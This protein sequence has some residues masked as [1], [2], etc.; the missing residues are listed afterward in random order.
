MQDF[1]EY[2]YETFGFDPKFIRQTASGKRYFA[3]ELL[4]GNIGVCATLGEKYD[5]T[6]PDEIYLELDRH[7][8][9][10]TAY[11]N[12]LL[13]Y[14]SARVKENKDITDLNMN[15]YRHIVFVG[16]F[17][18]V[19]EKLRQQGIRFDYID[20]RATDSPDNRI[21]N[22]EEVLSRADLLIITATAITNGTLNHLL[23]L[24]PFSDKYILGPSS[25]LLPDMAK[26]GIKGIFGTQF[27]P[28]D[29]RVLG[30]ISQDYG[31]RYFLHKG[32]KVMV[33][34]KF[35]KTK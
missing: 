12:A 2:L 17:D 32:K 30:L 20:Q 19:F 34:C 21:K 3:I 8:V 18:P 25:I 27:K 11:Y 13:N 23:D 1:L 33:E 5:P 6:I 4:N 14:R 16:K 7:R 26:W 9:I 35:T 22:K 31:T 28:Y 24:S 29:S 15:N 10:L